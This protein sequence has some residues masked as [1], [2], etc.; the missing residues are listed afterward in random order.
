MG[1]APEQAERVLALAGV[2][3]GPSGKILH[4]CRWE[5]VPQTWL[6]RSTFCSVRLCLDTLKF[7]ISERS[8]Y[9]RGDDQRRASFFQEIIQNENNKVCCV[10]NQKAAVK[11]PLIS[12]GRVGSSLEVKKNKKK[13]HKKLNNTLL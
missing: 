4:C 7:Q 8:W 6:G 9:D 5:M 10:H 2:R 11:P 12:V 13:T 3:L 1:G